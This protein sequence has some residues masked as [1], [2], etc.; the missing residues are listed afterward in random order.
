MQVPTKLDRSRRRSQTDGGVSAQA[1]HEHNKQ[2]QRRMR[3]MSKRMSQSMPRIEPG[4]GGGSNLM[5]RT[6]SLSRTHWF[7]HNRSVEIVFFQMSAVIGRSPDL[8]AR[9]SDKRVRVGVGVKTVAAAS[10]TVR[11][12]WAL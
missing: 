9:L 3:F 5:L 8:C 6:V 10:P 11:V 7:K 4:G 2:R 12:L 1:M